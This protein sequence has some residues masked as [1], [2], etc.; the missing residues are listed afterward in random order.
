M[1]C[2]R[3]VESSKFKTSSSPG[4]GL[5]SVFARPNSSRLTMTVFSHRGQNKYTA[6]SWCLQ[7][8]GARNRQLF[9]TLSL[10]RSGRIC[11]QTNNA[12][13]NIAVF[14]II[15]LRHTLMLLAP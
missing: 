12:G 6:G 13:G 4:V 5:V 9:N 11:H 14:S 15:G 2:M 1:R 8:A 3:L 7:C 10:F